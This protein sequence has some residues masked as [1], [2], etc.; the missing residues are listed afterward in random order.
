MLAV[1]GVLNAVAALGYEVRVPAP[2]VR[3]AS[4]FLLMLSAVVVAPA[5]YLVLEAGSTKAA[6][7]VWLGAVALAHLAAAGA[8]A[9]RAPQA[10]DARDLCLVLSVLLAD[11]AIALA[12]HGPARALAWAAG[13]VLFAALGRRLRERGADGS[14]REHGL[15]G[16]GLGGHIGLALIQAL[17]QLDLG[18][19]GPAGG[20]GGAVAAL[21]ALAAG[22]LVSARLAD[23]G[24]E[25]LRVGLDA[26]GLVA[27]AMIALLTLGGPA[28]TAAWALEA[29][30]LAAIA[31]RGGDRVA[32]VAAGVHLGA[33]A[34]YAL[35]DQASP[36]HLVD[37]AVALGP[38]A[39]GTG[40]VAAAALLIARGLEP[41]GLRRALH[42]AAGVTVLY[43]ASLAAV[44][45]APDAAGPA[46]L[47]LGAAQQ[48]QLQLST[49]WALTGVAGLLLGLRRDSAP[50]RLA[51]LGLLGLTTAKVFLFDLATLSAG[52]RVGSFIAVGVLLLLASFAYARL[53]PEPLADLRAVPDGL[54]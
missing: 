10:R 41:A 35:V 17:A 31:R 50:L 1:F 37:G 39:L 4:A 43:L 11:A 48:G 51:A 30:A 16:L 3:A 22:C 20:D 49:L 12:A 46:A 6:A 25:E 14:A 21:A 52:Y 13:A 28:L 26:T 34:L 24:R 23:G 47:H 9:R 8:I 45:L 40:A 38:A 29:V 15:A 33:A 54:R 36:A 19:L 7:I 18:S 53:R 32:A 44:G 42:A 2:R 27:V 5:G